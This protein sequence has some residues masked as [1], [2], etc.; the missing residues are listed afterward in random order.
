MSTLTALLAACAAA[1]FAQETAPFEA[2]A[3]QAWLAA[4]AE[5]QAVRVSLETRREALKPFPRLPG[6]LHLRIGEDRP[7]GTPLG[8][9]LYLHGFADR[10]DNHGPLFEAWRKAGLRVVSFDLPGHGENRGFQNRLGWYSFERLGAL[11]LEVERRTREDP[12]RPLILAGW[13]TGGLLAVRMVQEDRFAGGRRPSGIVLF[14]PGVSLHLLVGRVGLVT[15]GTLTRNPD[16]PHVGGI[17]PRSPLLRPLFALRLLGNSWLWSGEPMPRDTPVL[18]LVGG[19]EE[20]RYAY[21]PGLKRW[22]ADQRKLGAPVTG[23]ECPGGYHELDNE[24]DPIGR[25]TRA[26]A[27]AFARSA[28]GAATSLDAALGA[29]RRF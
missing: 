17:H 23:V 6:R 11:A 4:S 29:C 20:D 13:S 28:A 15:E 7:E 3:A 10:L 14:A 5:A 18:V 22:A 9:V 8:D 25:E 12:R 21:S 2:R 26:A 16:P 19:T 1:A 27:A 24:P